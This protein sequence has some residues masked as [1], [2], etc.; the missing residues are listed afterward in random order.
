MAAKAAGYRSRAA[1]KLMELQKRHQLIQAGSRILDLGAAPGSWSQVALQ[2]AKPGGKIIAV[3][4]KHID[5]IP[6]VETLQAD[7]LDANFE[8]LIRQKVPQPFDLVLSDMAPN[9]TGIKATDQQQA[10]Q[11][12]LRASEIASKLLT[13]RGHFIFKVFQGDSFEELLGQLKKTFSKIKARGLIASRSKSKEIF[14]I[15][16]L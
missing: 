14:C 6:G 4:I 7:V 2:H 10:A 3:D 1:Y 5:Q 11:L 13:P 9:L 15:A 12:V 8:K 16:R